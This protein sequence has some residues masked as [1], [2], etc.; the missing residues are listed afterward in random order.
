MIRKKEVS[1]L[2]ITEA[3]ENQEEGSTLDNGA[4]QEP[5]AEFTD[6][7]V[8]KPTAS[9]LTL[10]AGTEAETQKDK[11]NAVWHE[12]KNSHV[13]G[14]HLTGTLGKVERLENGGFDMFVGGYRL[15]LMPELRFMLHSEGALGDGNMLNLSDPLLDGLLAAADVSPSESGYARAYSQIQQDVAE[16]LPIICLAFRKSALLT[17]T[18]IKGEIRPSFDNVFANIHE[19]WL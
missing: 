5:A 8:T 10:E 15:S 6:E 19:W 16:R 11:E 18:R 7:V 17:D 9:I 1:A 14:S 4:V 2:E 12:I 13:T 3:Y